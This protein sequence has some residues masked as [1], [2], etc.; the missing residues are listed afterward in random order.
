MD[1]LTPVVGEMHIGTA[2]ADDAATEFKVARFHFLPIMLGTFAAA[3]CGLFLFF[4]DKTILHG[5]VMDA[6]DW[7]H[8]YGVRP[9]GCG[10]FCYLWQ[11][12]NEHRVVFS[13]ALVALDLRWFDRIGPSFIMF[14]LLLVFAMAA[15][16][17]REIMNSGLPHSWK[18]AAFAVAILL[19]TPVNTV[20]MVSE[21]TSSPYLQTCA[22]ALFSLVLLDGSDEQGRFSNYRRIAAILAACCTAFGTSAGLVIWPV[23][24]WSAWRGRL[25]W[26][27]IAGIGLAGVVFIGAY[28]WHLPGHAV[29]GV[30][31]LPGVVESFDY[32]IRFL[33][34]PWGAR[35]PLLLWPGRFI[36]FCMLC[37]GTIALLRASFSGRPI[38]RLQRV[39]LGLILFSLL[40]AA[41]APLARL[42][43]NQGVEVPI[44]YGM[45]VVPLHSGLLLW[46]LEYLYEYR[47]VVER[48][49]TPWMIVAACAIWLTQQVA[50]GEYATAAVNQYNDAWS[51]FVAGEWTPDMQDHVYPLRDSAEA[52]LAYLRKIN[53]HLVY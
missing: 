4:V 37:L 28:T 51:R 3:N 27:W 41:S 46:S 13:R 25:R 11:P 5:P 19:L 18:Y 33:G 45:F 21:P 24:I 43:L 22:F 39:G 30:L 8:A 29:Q 48:I 49:F 23:L 50:V 14:G 9:P 16:I 40:I 17:G 44:R 10:F 15:A 34:L 31:T 2:R 32:I 35:L 7:I 47:R 26:P 20:I 42:N 6:F 52:Y 38:T 36:G 1:P 12:H 53:Y